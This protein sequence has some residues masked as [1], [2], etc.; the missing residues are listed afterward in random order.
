MIC[1]QHLV[2]AVTI[3]VNL[4]WSTSAYSAVQAEKWRPQDS[5]RGS[6]WLRDAQNQPYQPAPTLATH[7]D[8]EISG[9]LAQVQVSQTFHNP[10][11]HWAEGVYVFPLPEQAAVARLRLVIGKQHIEGQIKERSQAKNS[12]QLAKEA[13]QRATLLEAERPNIFT[14]S[15]ANIAPGESIKVEIEYQQTVGFGDGTFRLRLPM[16]VA[17]RYIPGQ[18]LAPD[19]AVTAFTGSGWA[20]ATTAVADAARITPPVRHPHKGPINPLSLD[21]QLN[22]G[23]P[24]AEI[25]SSYHPIDTQWSGEGHYRIRLAD[26]QV[27]AERDFEL[28]WRPAAISAPQA[29][30]FVEQRGRQQYGL[31]ML[32]PPRPGAE[33]TVAGREVVFVI[34]TSG[35]MHGESIEQARSALLLALQRLDQRDRFNVIRFSDTTTSLFATTQSATAANLRFAREF[36]HGLEAGGGTEMRPALEMALQQHSQQQNIRQVIFLTDGS[37]GNEHELFELVRQQLGSSRL[38]TVGI[39]S[40]PNSHFM[41]KAAEYGRGTFTYIGKTT[42]VSKKATALF[43]KLEQAALTDIRLELPSRPDLEVLPQR[44]PD[45]Y[46]GEPLLVAVKGRTLPDWVAVHGK[47]GERAWSTRVGLEGEQPSNAVAPEWGG[48]KIA[49][50]MTQLYEAE[51][52]DARHSLRQQIVA[53]ALEHQLVSRYTS[54]VAVDLTPERRPSEPLHQR[55]LKTNLPAGWSHQ[56]VFG[57]PQ[58]ATPA[59]LH[60]ASG[61]LML[62]IASLIGLWAWRRPC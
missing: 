53:T 40:A 55:A 19:E 57:L 9:M 1:L 17:P 60:L 28:V 30:W 38:F 23:V 5:N 31:L 12:Y 43:R 47:L 45:L 24:L 50:L 48:R 33:R 15:L 49:L 4:L 29:A 25:S 11:S 59:R 56:H 44:I 20:R 41:R 14:T 39:G 18:V 21:I 26:G 8:M 7:V 32:V 2:A 37:V 46:A 22:A 34:D 52:D 3:T 61:V 16:V 35:S 13:G 62:L 27:P 36:L 42:E 54:L 51:N 10:S 6:L 58:T